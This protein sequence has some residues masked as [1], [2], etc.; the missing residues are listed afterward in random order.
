M[1]FLTIWCSCVLYTNYVFIPYSPAP[2]RITQTV[3]ILD[4]T[5]YKNDT[6]TL[7]CYIAG[8]PTPAV[9]WTKDGGKI[10]L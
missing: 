5:F 3:P 2:V 8:D 10:F 4:R 7:E 1:Q 6:I 9:A